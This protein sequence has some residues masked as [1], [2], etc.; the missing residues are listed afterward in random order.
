MRSRNSSRALHGARGLKHAAVSMAARIA[1]SRPSR[2]A[3]IETTPTTSSAPCRSGR[4]LH[5]AR[6]LKHIG[7]G[8]GWRFRGRALHGARGLKPHASQS[9]FAAQNRRALHGARGLKP[10]RGRGPRLDA[11]S[12][13]SRGAWIETCSRRRAT[14]SGASRPSRGAWIETASSWRR[15]TPPSSRALHGAR[16]LKLDAVCPGFLRGQVAPFTGRVD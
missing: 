10:K 5:G 9:R 13:P 1:A 8:S 14:A 2:G 12:R 16:G 7:R 3:W 11:A 15:W 4:A 6:G